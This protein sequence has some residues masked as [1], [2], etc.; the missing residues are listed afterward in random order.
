MVTEKRFSWIKTNSLPSF[1]LMIFLSLP[2]CSLID[3]ICCSLSSD[4]LVGYLEEVEYARS[5]GSPDCIIKRAVIH[6]GTNLIKYIFL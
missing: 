2:A 3:T 1:T 4:S 6:V 5:F